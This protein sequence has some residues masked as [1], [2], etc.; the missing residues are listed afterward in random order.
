M[1][2]VPPAV[3]HRRRR[4]PYRDTLDGLETHT[5]GAI[6]KLKRLAALE[7]DPHRR[8]LW[9]QAIVALRRVLQLVHREKRG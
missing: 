5:A 7:D 4:D 2:N 6:D 1:S 8:M 3:H 9:G